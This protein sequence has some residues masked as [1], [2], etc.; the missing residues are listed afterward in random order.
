[1]SAKHR[2]VRHGMIRLDSPGARRLGFTSDRFAG[3]LWREGD[4]II[5]SMILSY[6]RG[7]FR[8]LVERILSM[9][10][11]VEVPTPLGRMRSA[12]SGMSLA[13]SSSAPEA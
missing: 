7:N 1:M 6:K 3:W 13:N 11:A 9:G 12:V 2:S 5:V 4:T 10:L 8:R